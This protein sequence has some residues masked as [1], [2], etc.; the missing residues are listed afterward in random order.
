LPV[1]CIVCAHFYR[2]PPRT[3]MKLTLQ[4][5]I[6]SGMAIIFILLSVLTIWSTLIHEYEMVET[7]STEEAK[8][9]G[10]SY[11]DALNTLMLTGALGE[12]ETLR[13]KNLD[14]KNILDLRLIRGEPIVA[15]FG[16]GNSDQVAKD[17]LDERSLK[18]ETIK[19]MSHNAQGRVIKVALP[20]IAGSNVNGTNCLTC[21]PVP[22]GSV[23]GVVRIDYSLQTLDADIHENLLTSVFIN[24]L[25]C[26]LSGIVVYRF[27]RSLMRQLGGEPDYAVEALKKLAQGDLDVQI[28]TRQDDQESLLYA[29]SRMQRQLCKVVESVLR[30]ADSLSVVA[31]Q[32]KTNTQNLSQ[33]A[34]QQAEHA[35]KTT[36]SINILNEAVR[37]NVKNAKI[38]NESACLSANDA[39][40]GGEAVHRTI[41]AMQEIASKITVIEDVAYKTNILSLNAAIEAATAG[42][43]G[44]GFAVVADEVRKLADSSQ[45]TAQQ[46]EQLTENGLSVA[47]EAGTLL[48]ALVPT[49]QH[50][51]TLVS[52]ITVSSEAQA[53]AIEEIN[54]SMK[55]IDQVAQ[56]NAAMSTHLA[57][58]AI[59]MEDQAKQLQQS[60][61][62][63]KL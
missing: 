54:V 58:V 18:G 41:L 34:R 36:H 6:F 38:T 9:I 43:V 20:I 8:N 56:Q 24:A 5:R 14:N 46:I 45:S 27:T 32:V 4:A 61:A 47:N 1:R 57:D 42:S 31:S 15:M 21:H 10:K 3:T 25:L 62:F 40:T 44:K 7:M 12:K 17:A 37:L 30:N 55:Q 29:L 52:E 13:N 35:V 49:I 53:G 26:I 28:N 33:L 22:E 50:T 51:A 48:E 23:M 2:C 39:R 16:K 19:Q 63:F 59:K 11:F 60:V